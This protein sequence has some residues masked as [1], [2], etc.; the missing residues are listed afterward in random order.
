VIFDK[1]KI[2]RTSCTKEI[3]FQKIKNGILGKIKR[4]LTAVLIR[5]VLFKM[6]GERVYIDLS[7]LIAFT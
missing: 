6:A 7:C 4:F 5:A 3:L 2:K 1:K